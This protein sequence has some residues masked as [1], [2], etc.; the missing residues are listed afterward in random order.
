MKFKLPKRQTTGAVVCFSCQ[1]IVAVDQDQCCH[2]GQPHPGLWGY[3]RLIRRLGADF[4]FIKIV[5]VGCIGLYIITLLFDLPGVRSESAFKLL[6]P[7]SY[8][9]AI[10]GSTGSI[11]LFVWGRWWTV[12]SAAWLHGDLWHLGFNLAWL[13]YLS[14]MVVAGY[15][16]GRLV[17]IYALT[18]LTSSLLTSCVA[19]YWLTLPVFFQGA[20][21]SVGAS[22]GVFGLL[23][24]LLLYGQ[25]SGHQHILRQLLTLVVITFVLS[26]FVG[27]VDNWGHL[28]GVMGGYLIG[29]TPWFNPNQP[30]RLY[31][32]GIAAGALVLMAISMIVSPLHGLSL[33]Q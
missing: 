27:N 18:T 10:F 8:S 14:P 22:G 16:A 21:F 11:P 29:W 32:L 6:A 30:Q 28:G 20:R 4:G 13:H 33:M 17:S 1:K 5:S 9:L 26:A 15:G 19:Q 12:L 24:A 3:S 25:L 31:H 23:G 7:S 2:C